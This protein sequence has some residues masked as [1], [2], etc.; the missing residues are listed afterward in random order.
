MAGLPSGNTVDDHDRIIVDEAGYLIV[1]AQIALQ[2]GG[3]ADT[4]KEV[5]A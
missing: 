1:S 2:A 3:S 5:T 4:S